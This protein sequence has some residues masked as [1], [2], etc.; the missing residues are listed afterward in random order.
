MKSKARRFFSGG[1]L[2][3]VILTAGCTGATEQPA[4]QEGSNTEIPPAQII[5]EAA[6]QPPQT[7]PTEVDSSTV[8]PTQPEE[9]PPTQNLTAATLPQTLNL[10]P[11]DWR[12]WPAVPLLTQNVQQIYARGQEL[13]RDPQGFSIF[14]D[15][16]STPD[17]FLGSFELDQ[18]IFNMLTP[19]L[20]DTALYF[21]HS[22]NRES[23][24]A[25]PGTT[26]GALLWVEWHDGLYDCQPNE[27]PV[28]CELR[29]NNPAFVLLAVGTHYETRNEYYLRLIIEELLGQGVL[30]ILSTKADNREGDHSLN[31]QTAQLALEYNIP[32]WNFWSVTA[33]LPGNGLYIKEGEEHLG[34]IYFSDEVKERHRLSA[35]QTIDAIWRAA[36]ATQ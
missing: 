31:L 24:T 6:E 21:S 16:Q 7:E 20:Q 17:T 27:T 10:E 15:C 25:K 8:D 35:L 26:T 1:I 23:P 29:I 2:L 3:V 19:D 28:Q 12:N 9:Q 18:T 4:T 22:F 14:G 34:A 32:M 5:T 13:G 11:E 33:D 30:P 36:S